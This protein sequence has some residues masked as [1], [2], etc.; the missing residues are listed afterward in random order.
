MTLHYSP[1][2]PS[3][4]HAARCKTSLFHRHATSVPFHLRAKPATSPMPPET[5]LHKYPS[6]PIHSTGTPPISRPAKSG[7]W[8][9]SLFPSEIPCLHSR[10]TPPSPAQFRLSRIVPCKGSAHCPRSTSSE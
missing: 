5:S 4:P 9:N 1:P 2:P 10:S 3:I 7:R 6:L 8:H